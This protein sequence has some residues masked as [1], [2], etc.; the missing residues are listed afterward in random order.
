M[1]EPRDAKVTKKKYM[2]INYVVML[3]CLAVPSAFAQGPLTPPGAPA[4]TM[5]TLDQIRPGIPI[6]NLPFTISSWGHYY[7]TGNLTV[8]DTN[9]PAITVS[10]GG[11]TID[12]NGAGNN[13]GG[14]AVYGS[15]NRIEG[16]HVSS[17]ADKGIWLLA[18]GNTVF[19][20]SLRGNALPIDFVFGNDIGPQGPASSST[21]PWA[22]ITY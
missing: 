18:G 19:K 4:P 21:S 16:N 11:V 15:A 17:N 13:E 8:F 9:Q 2:K 22:N 1:H 20:N 3:C 5:K 12:L 7:L 14:I 10:A 6:T